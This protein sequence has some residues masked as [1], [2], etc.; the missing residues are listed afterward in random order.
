[1]IYY[2]VWF[3]GTFFKVN[4]ET[5]VKCLANLMK[6]EISC[7]SY[8]VCHVKII[9]AD[10][11]LLA[12]RADYILHP[13]R[14]KMK[15][16]LNRVG[17]FVRVNPECAHRCQ[18]AHW[19]G[20]SIRQVWD[21]SSMLSDSANGIKVQTFWEKPT[22]IKVKEKPKKIR[23]NW[24]KK[25]GTCNHDLVHADRNIQFGH[26]SSGP[27]NTQRV[28]NL[29]NNRFIKHNEEQRRHPA[30]L[31]TVTKISETLTFMFYYNNTCFCFLLK[32]HSSLFQPAAP[33]TPRGNQPLRGD[34]RKVKLVPAPHWRGWSG[35]TSHSSSFFFHET[36][37]HEILF[38]STWYREML[39]D[40][41]QV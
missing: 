7:S 13:F 38:A 22:N 30:S 35:L 17:F 2:S 9:T 12:N 32:A 6:N 16:H 3:L 4:F 27:I 37:W 21:L 5:M 15:S 24:N 18:M 1:M 10:T 20:T 34:M 31:L 41:K 33:P 26:F 25:T 19:W 8:H 23:I 14:E 29:R 40:L 39:T 36:L 11:R 28:I